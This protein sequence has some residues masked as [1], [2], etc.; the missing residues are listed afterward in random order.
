MA[1][2]C[3]APGTRTIA[4]RSVHD[5]DQ[6]KKSHY[7]QFFRMPCHVAE[8]LF[9]ADDAAA[10][11]KVYQGKPSEAR[12]QE[13]VR[14]FLEPGALTGYCFERLE[15]KSHWLPDEIPGWLA[16]R[17]LE[18]FMAPEMRIHLKL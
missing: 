9:L 3:G 14:R 16:A 1:S 18:H 10:L 4:L 7:T 2:C 13:N 15:G 5:A 8:S 12:I 17:L 11:G 6:Q